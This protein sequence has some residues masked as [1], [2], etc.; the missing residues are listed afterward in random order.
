M[1]DKLDWLEMAQAAATNAAEY[2]DEGRDDLAAE[3]HDLAMRRAAI[4]Q[5]EAQTRQAAAMERIA[6]KLVA[7]EPY[8]ARLAEYDNAGHIDEI[9]QQADAAYKRATIPAT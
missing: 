2:R 9:W 8:L 3:W 4:A 5:A 6:E 7:I 1:D